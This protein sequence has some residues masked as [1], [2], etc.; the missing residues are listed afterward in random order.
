MEESKEAY[1]SLTD[2]GQIVKS[3]W[4]YLRKNVWLLL[5][6]GIISGAIGIL[7]FLSSN[8][9]ILLILLLYWKKNLRLV[10]CPD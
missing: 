9:N 5:I 6:G 1:T 8:Q 3:F 10:V 4:I 7:I 2:L